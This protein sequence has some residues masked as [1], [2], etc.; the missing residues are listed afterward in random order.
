MMSHC[1]LI[2][3]KIKV[4]IVFVSLNYLSFI[5]PAFERPTKFMEKRLYREEKHCRLPC[6]TAFIVVQ[7]PMRCGTRDMDPDHASEEEEFVAR[8]NAVAFT[9]A[10]QE[11][12]QPTEWQDHLHILSTLSA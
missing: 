6:R 7:V 10:L 4:R 2:I 5:S 8:H 12:A 3:L 11:L 9:D 1:R